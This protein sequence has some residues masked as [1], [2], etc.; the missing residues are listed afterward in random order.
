MSTWCRRCFG[1]WDDLALLDWLRQRIWPLERAHDAESVYWSARLGL[2][3]MLLGGT[4][5][6]LDMATVQHTDAVFQAAEES[7]MRAFIGNAMMDLDNGAG[8]GAS[9]TANLEEAERLRLRWD[10]TAQ[11]RLRF[12]YAPRFVPSCSEAL[13][14]ETARLARA[15]GCLIHTHA[16]ENRDE[17]AM[18]RALT[19]R[20]NIVYL[21]ELGLTGPDVVLAHCI[22]LTPAEVAILAETDTTLTHCPGSN[23]KL[24]SGLAQVPELR[25]RGI[26]W[27]LGAD[28]APC[29]NRLDIFSEMRLAAL[30][31]KPRLGAEAAPARE[32]LR[33]AT[34]DG[35]QALGL[36]AGQIAPG[37]AADLV[38]LDPDLPHSFG[39]GPLDSKVVYSM[40]P[41]NVRA[42]W[43]G[44]QEVVSEGRVRGWDTAE[45]IR[46][47]GRALA[48]VRA[49][50]GL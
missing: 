23:C 12:A 10:R 50:A 41:A 16:S 47:A 32:V 8:L 19:G 14:R 42:V 30:L 43:I 5:A 27:A 22:H 2:T 44:G 29:N 49:R 21:H 11:G 24:A 28:G 15:H 18:V 6:I 37:R 45:T 31:Q 33:M 4:T 13:L 38:L 26:R 3:E 7:G 17:V 1:A 48:R 40:T 9:T 20:D 46:E 35:A 25:A 36:P 34:A 39:G